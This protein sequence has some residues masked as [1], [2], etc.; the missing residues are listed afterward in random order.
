MERPAVNIVRT[1]SQKIKRVEDASECDGSGFQYTVPPKGKK[2]GR[3]CSLV[4]G[5]LL[6]SNGMTRIQLPT[7]QKQPK[8]KSSSGVVHW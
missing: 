8:Q 7:V 1:L 6:N 4:V 3:G 5:P 2:N